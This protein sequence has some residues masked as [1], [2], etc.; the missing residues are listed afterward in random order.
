M[1]GDFAQRFNILDD[2]QSAVEPG[3]VSVQADK[4]AEAATP[5]HHAQLLLDAR[6]RFQQSATTEAA[7][8]REMDIDQRFRASQQWPDQ[9]KRDRDSDGRPC[10]TVN[11]LPAFIKQVTNQQRQSKPAI[12]IN[13]VDSGSDP[14]TAEVLQ[15]IIRH[16]EVQSHADVAYDQA[17]DNQVTIGRGFFRIVIEWASDDS[18]QQEIRFQRIRN[19]FTVY[20]DPTCHQP[21]YSD[22][23]YA[24]VVEDIPKD[25][26]RLRYGEGQMQSA[27]FFQSIG[28]RA[29]DW[30]PEG[31]IRVAEYFYVE[32]THEQVSLLSNGATLLTAAAKSPEMVAYMAQAGIKVLRS[33]TVERHQVKWAKI[34]GGTVLE[35]A[36]W[37]GQWIPI[38]PVLGDEVDINGQVDLRGMVRDARDPQRM[39]NFWLSAATE[40]IALAPRAPFIGMEGQFEGHTAKWNQANKRN[41][42]F[43][44]YKGISL[45]QTYAP[46]PQRQTAE[47]AIAA[48]SQAI[49]QADND[50][51][52]VTGLYD[53]SLGERGPDQ[54][55]KAI[56]ARQRQ[57]D[58]ANINWLDNLGRA[59]RHGGRILLDLIPRI[60]DAPRVL[61]ILGLDDQPQTVMVHSG[62]ADQL[63]PQDQMAEG[64]AGIYD[65]SVGTYDVTV[66]VGPSYQSRRQEG[67]EAMLSFIQ[68]FPPSAP[69]LGDILAGSMDWPGAQ[70]VAKRLKKM[71]P[72]EL[73]EPEPGGPPEVPPEV[74]QQMQQMDGM[75]KQL[76][77]E[78]M[79]LQDEKKSQV[80]QSQSRERVALIQAKTDLAIAALNTRTNASIALVK[81]HMDQ[82]ALLIAQGHAQELQQADHAQQ[83]HADAASH[84]QELRMATLG[85]QQDAASQQMDQAHAVGLQG[86]DQAH[87]Q[88]LQDSAQTHEAD[89]NDADRQAADAQ[90]AASPAESV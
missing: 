85:G 56:L 58:I 40:A 46:P 35:E 30:F 1:N 5:E 19:P 33:R 2:G 79:A 61:R 8:R 66:S 62:Q 43:L 78:N 68:A 64:V 36:D 24:F 75:L 52:A 34:T 89:Q 32:T 63:P 14:K 60:Y 18:W 23:R 71:L 16:I 28:D 84:A 53:A 42:P 9:V 26:F 17:C 48:I 13:P 65:L 7:L 55:G 49:R 74:Q 80:V 90:A 73:K 41:F 70:T 88:Q 45:G 50:L 3:R 15:G 72:P 82:F 22:A 59:I 4:T 44:E 10:M 76:H 86:M 27:L 38:V 29:P 12:Q 6:T 31:K 67:V 81:E 57:G 39:Y 83:A 51:K 87:A 77:D 25:E 47:P 11:R 69:A 21:D 20:F 37:P 54:S